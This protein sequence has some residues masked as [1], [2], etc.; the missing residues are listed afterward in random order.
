MLVLGAKTPLLWAD[1]LQDAS[2]AALVSWQINS[3][4]VTL[5]SGVGT[6]EGSTACRA[7]AFLSLC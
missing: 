2:Q 7:G 6:G 5:W 4:S 3:V 1:L